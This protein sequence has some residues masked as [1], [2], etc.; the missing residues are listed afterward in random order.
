MN[1]KS[2]LGFKEFVTP[3]IMKVVYWVGIIGIAIVGL[4][5]V[6]RG[7][8]YDSA[9][10]LFGGI[11]LLVLAPLYLRV[12]CELILVAFQISTDLSAMRFCTE[13]R[14]KSS[15]EEAE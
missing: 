1:P 11:F 3:S 5:Q 14:E 15:D 12:L 7:L 4:A 2:L 13:K 10:E 6:I 9:T 8:K